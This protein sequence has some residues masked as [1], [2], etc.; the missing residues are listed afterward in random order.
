MAADPNQYVR[1]R[2]DGS[3]SSVGISLIVLAFVLEGAF[4]LWCFG[5]I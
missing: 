1:F 4:V 3:E 2:D 5:A